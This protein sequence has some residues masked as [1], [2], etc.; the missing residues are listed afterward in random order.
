MN[1]RKIGLES[2][3]EFKEKRSLDEI[4]SKTGYKEVATIEELELSE[5]EK[6]SA[7][8]FINDET[9]KRFF[10]AERSDGK[11]AKV[12]IFEGKE[13]FNGH[14]FSPFGYKGHLEC[15]DWSDH[16]LEGS[17]LDAKERKEVK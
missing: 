17:L 3:L 8:D 5:E 2:K 7:K 11:Q 12:I 13:T 14:I 4:M 10:V 1:E 9:S 16:E 15:N 6:K